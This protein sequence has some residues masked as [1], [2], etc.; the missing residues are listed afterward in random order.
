MNNGMRILIAIGHPAHVHFFKNFILQCQQND[1]QVRIVAR[2]KEVTIDLIRK[3]GFDYDLFAP[4][5]KHLVEKMLEIPVNDLIFYRA[6]KKFRPTMLMGINDYSAAHIG[7][8]TGTPSVIFTDTEGV[9]FNDPL[10][11]P[12]ASCLCT[13]S[14]FLKS[15]GKKTS[16]PPPKPVSTRPRHP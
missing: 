13:P 4:H 3:Y 15:L 5:K 12:F 6:F 14:S 8:L 2:D 11:F 9:R 1:H 10:T 16:I 7:T